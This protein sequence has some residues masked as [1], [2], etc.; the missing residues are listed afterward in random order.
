MVPALSVRW[1]HFALYIL[2]NT[3]MYCHLTYC[4]QN[5]VYG[6]YWY[7]FAVSANSKYGILPHNA[8][9][10]GL[11]FLSLKTVTTLQILI[12]TNTFV[13]GLP[14]LLS[15]MSWDEPSMSHPIMS[16]LTWWCATCPGITNKISTWLL[17]TKYVVR[18]LQFIIGPTQSCPNGHSFAVYE[19]WKIFSQNLH[20]P[21]IAKYV[22]GT[23]HIIHYLSHPWINQCRINRLIHAFVMRCWCPGAMNS[24][25]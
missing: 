21:V 1:C 22:P 11:I 5:V 17:P 24:V 14:A 25:V 15:L 16:C 7:Y 9:A 6:I 8:L 20:F 12:T 13:A 10:Y 18:K 4:A 3:Y 19:V 2:Y 23:C